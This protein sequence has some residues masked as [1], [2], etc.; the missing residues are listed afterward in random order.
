MGAATAWGGRARAWRRG[1][2]GVALA[3]AGRPVRH[4]PIAAGAE[5]QHRGESVVRGEQVDLVV[6]PVRRG[7]EIGQQ[8]GLFERLPDKAG[9]ELVTHRAVRAVGGDQVG[10]LDRLLAP[11]A[12]AQRNARRITLLAAVRERD[13]TFDHDAPLGQLLGED[14]LRIGLVE[15]QQIWIARLQR[16]EIERGDSPSARMQVS[17]ARAMPK[18]E[19]RLDDAMLLEQLERARLNADRA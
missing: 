4:E 13:G 12:V 11:I 5:R 18:R 19:K 8:E 14:P 3:A 17:E 1:F 7:A 2:T 9:A 10:R 15:Q 16:I 6:G